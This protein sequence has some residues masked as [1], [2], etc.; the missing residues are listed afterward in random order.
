MLTFQIGCKIRFYRKK[1]SFKAYLTSQSKRH[2]GPIRKWNN[3][4]CKLCSQGLTKSVPKRSSSVKEIRHRNHPKSCK[5]SMKPCTRA[6]TSP[7]RSKAMFQHNTEQ[8]H[9]T[10]IVILDWVWLKYR[11][12]L[13]LIHGSSNMVGQRLRIRETC[14]M[15]FQERLHMKCKVRLNYS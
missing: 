4:A 3:L 13:Q 10:S 11:W 14:P 7:F 12:K 15:V 8:D 9:K 1:I 6:L 5:S 2:R